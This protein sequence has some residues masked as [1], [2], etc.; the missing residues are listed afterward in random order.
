MERTPWGG[1][2]GGVLKEGGFQER[3]GGRSELESGLACKGFGLF[4]FA[5]QGGK[6]IPNPK[7]SYLSD[8]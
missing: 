6:S 1:V 5:P 3:G 8:I 2:A 4:L 7:W